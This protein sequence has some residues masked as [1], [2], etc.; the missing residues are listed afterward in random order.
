MV[1]TSG[2]EQ[3][4]FNSVLP[5][6]LPEFTLRPRIMPYVFPLPAILL[7]EEAFLAGR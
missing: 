6:S 3:C 4:P 2:L 7:T 1:S 5:Q